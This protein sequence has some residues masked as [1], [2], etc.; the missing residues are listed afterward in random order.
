[1]PA[2]SVRVPGSNPLR[3]P[4]RSLPGIRGFDGMVIFA[5]V[6]MAPFLGRSLS[7]VWSVVRCKVWN[8]ELGNRAIDTY[9]SSLPRGEVGG[10]LVVIVIPDPF[11]PKRSSEAAR[12]TPTSVSVGGE[13]ADIVRL[14]QPL[15]YSTTM[16]CVVLAAVECH[17][18][19]VRL[20]PHKRSGSRSLLSAEARNQRFRASV[21]LGRQSARFLY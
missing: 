16:K 17:P 20:L 21:G 11:Q 14:A 7:S 15:G 13:H 18:P 6:P 9:S 3:I 12:L 2:A 1:M 5:M 8:S 19:F 4:N 10:G